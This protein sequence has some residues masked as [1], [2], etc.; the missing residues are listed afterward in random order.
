MVKSILHRGLPTELLALLV[1]LF[2]FL[3]QH[4]LAHSDADLG[5]APV[6]L[7]RAGGMD[8]LGKKKLR[9]V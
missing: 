6:L 3:V 1:L 4:Q 2:S 5:P 9:D 8:L 7:G